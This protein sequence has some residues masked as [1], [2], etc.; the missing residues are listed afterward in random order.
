M[1][2]HYQAPSIKLLNCKE[3]DI[4]L[5]STSLLDDNEQFSYGWLEGLL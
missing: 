5:A 3:I 4:L 2:N 1:K